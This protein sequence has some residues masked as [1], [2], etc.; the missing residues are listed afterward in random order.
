MTLPRA[1]EFSA[2][3][4]AL[5]VTALL[6]AFVLSSKPANASAPNGLPATMASTSAQTVG[7]T[8]STPVFATSTGCAARII[9]TA[10]SSIMVTFT[11]KFGD[12]P[13]AANGLWQGA[14]TTVAYDSGLYGCGA[15]KIYSFT[16]QQIRA[17]ESF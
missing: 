3:I 6:F 1:I 14:S 12:V 11:D 9:G 15:V 13:N 2:I 5:F 16:S 8:P 17:A 4:G 10:S 7:T